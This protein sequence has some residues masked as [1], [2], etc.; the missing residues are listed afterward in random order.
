MV[1]EISQG[2]SRQ[3]NTAI[4]RNGFGLLPM[5]K[6]VIRLTCTI[7]RLLP[8][9]AQTDHRVWH[10]S[11]KAVYLRKERKEHKEHYGFHLFTQSS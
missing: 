9:P 7:R 11:G 6:K 1:M 10:I 4:A 3:N 2:I 8:M 5:V